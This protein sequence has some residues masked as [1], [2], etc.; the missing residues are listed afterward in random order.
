MSSLLYIFVCAV[1]FACE[2]AADIGEDVALGE[3]GGEDVLDKAL[4]GLAF[5]DDVE[6]DHGCPPSTFFSQSSDRL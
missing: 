2:D 5:G 3:V 4:L 6:A 1:I